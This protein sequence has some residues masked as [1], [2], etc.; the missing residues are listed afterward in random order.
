MIN[1]SHF[2]IEVPKSIRAMLLD[3]DLWGGLD[4]FTGDSPFAGYK[5]YDYDPDMSDDAIMDDIVP[6]GAG[7]I[8]IDYTDDPKQFLVAGDGTLGERGITGTQNRQFSVG[9]GFSYEVPF[10]IIITVIVSVRM[11]DSIGNTFE[12]NVLRS[13]DERI[14]SDVGHIERFFRSTNL[15][16]YEDSWIVDTLGVACTN[17]GPPVGADADEVT[18]QL[19]SGY[20]T[21]TGL[22]Q[23]R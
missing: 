9:G 18:E 17:W 8:L 22:I 4:W 13:S 2:F 7:V 16:I 21:L 23:V 12:S 11:S 6:N 10:S 5:I 20:V 19:R 14:K 3:N 1:A 15:S